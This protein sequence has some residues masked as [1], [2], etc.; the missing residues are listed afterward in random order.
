VSAGLR[1]QLLRVLLPPLISRALAC[2]HETSRV[3]TRSCATADSSGVGTRVGQVGPARV[4]LAAGGVPHQQRAARPRLLLRHN[5]RLLAPPVPVRRVG[6]AQAA[7]RGPPLTLGAPP[8]PLPPPPIVRTTNSRRVQSHASLQSHATEEVFSR[9]AA[10][11]ARR[12][13]VTSTRL[14]T[15]LLTTPHLPPHSPAAVA[16]RARAGQD[17][18]HLRGERDDHHGTRLL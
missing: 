18:V 3:H 12:R 16:P 10:C 4:Q 15:T 11:T 13:R 14:L 9:M 6:R 17:L 2:S 5:L 1:R 8:S 7:R